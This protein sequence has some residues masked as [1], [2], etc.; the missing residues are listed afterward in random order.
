M[1]GKTVLIT[2]GTGGI[3]KQTAIGLAKLGVHVVVSGR[4]AERGEAAVRDIQEASG[5]QQVKLLLADLSLLSETQRLIDAFLSR[6]SRL[7]IR[8][9]HR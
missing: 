8:S 1:Q 9:P 5:H 7:P 2:G 6:F 3:G 4:D